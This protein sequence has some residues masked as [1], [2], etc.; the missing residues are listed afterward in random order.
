MD[1]PLGDVWQQLV[2]F[3]FE[4]IG[5]RDLDVARIKETQDTLRAA[6]AGTE[7]VRSNI[8]ARVEMEPE[9]RAKVNGPF[10]LVDFQN[11]RQKRIEQLTGLART[12][13][14]VLDPAALAGFPEY[15]AETKDPGL[16]WAQ[17]SIV[18]HVLTV[19]I[20][21]KVGQVKNIVA[22]PSRP[23]QGTRGGESQWREIPMRIELIGM[24]PAAANFLFAIPFRAEEIKAAGLPEALPGKP[25][26]FLDGLLL[27]KQTPEKP[28]EVNLDVVISGFVPGPKGPQQ[29]P[30][31]KGALK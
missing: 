3:N 6:L 14:V 9:I 15:K 17:L 30:P 28:E 8:S 22:L 10:L 4:S 2:P 12:Q 31:E 21:S 5:V 18:H 25:A 29:R 16:L 23:D 26:L 13:Q 11:E 27:R 7:I 24:A 20:N 1:K 19:A